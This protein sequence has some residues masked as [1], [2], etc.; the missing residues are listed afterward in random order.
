MQST[1]RIHKTELPHSVLSIASLAETALN[2]ATG[3]FRSDGI[4]IRNV[5]IN[6]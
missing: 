1:V 3:P 5:K 2:S 4:G 6:N